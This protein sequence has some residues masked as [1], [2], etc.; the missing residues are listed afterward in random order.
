MKVAFYGGL[1]LN[2]VQKV[3]EAFYELRH[4]YG[5][6]N[7]VLVQGGGAQELLQRFAGA[8]GVPVT[9]LMMPWLLYGTDA[10]QAQ[11]HAILHLYPDM[12]VVLPGGADE[13]QMVA[14]CAAQDVPV[15]DLR[16]IPYIGLGDPAQLGHG[17]DPE[18]PA[19]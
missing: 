16:S 5:M 8:F 11:R 12:V 17:V 14:I 1:L 19:L 4:G 3:Y 9:S 18:A 7:L 2:N 10:P 6:D 15:W 13:E